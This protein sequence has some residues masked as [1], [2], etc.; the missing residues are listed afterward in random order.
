MSAS[1]LIAKNKYKTLCNVFNTKDSSNETKKKQINAIKCIK[2]SDIFGNPQ[3]TTWFEVPFTSSELKTMPNATIHTSNSHNPIVYSAAPLI[4][5]P[6][7][8]KQVEHMYR[9]FLK[10]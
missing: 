9:N 5:I 7:T 6:R 8:P 4:N 2:S 10:K 1:D 3:Q